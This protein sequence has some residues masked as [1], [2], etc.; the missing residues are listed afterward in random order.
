MTW[1]LSG[2][3]INFVFKYMSYNFQL[4]SVLLQKS[5]PLPKIIHMPIVLV[6][7]VIHWYF[8]GDINV[9]ST[10]YQ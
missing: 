4:T 8:T 7:F 6:I 9:T 5:T 2:R 10:D 3:K 1:I